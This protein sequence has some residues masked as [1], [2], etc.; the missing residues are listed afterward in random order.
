MHMAKLIDAYWNTTAMDL[1][2]ALANL[3]PRPGSPESL[4]QFLEISRDVSA[5]GPAPSGY[6]V[7]KN[8]KANQSRDRKALSVHSSFMETYLRNARKSLLGEHVHFLY[9]GTLR[10][11]LVLLHHFP[12]F[13]CNYHFSFL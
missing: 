6:M 13:L 10:V 7:S 9:K 2:D 5:N 4:P 11:L 8:K 1:I 3:A 12:E